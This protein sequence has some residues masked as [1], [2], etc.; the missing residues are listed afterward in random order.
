MPIVRQKTKRRRRRL[1]AVFAKLTPI[2]LMLVLVTLLAAA[3]GV[4]ALVLV[5]DRPPAASPLGDSPPLLTTPGAGIS[6]T[7]AAAPR[8]PET[9]RLVVPAGHIDLRV[10]PGDGFHVP[11]NLAVHY[12]GTS[13]PGGGGNSLFYAHAQ[14][15]MFAGLYDLH[16]G[17][18]IR[19]YRSDGSQVLYQVRTLHKVPATDLSV[20]KQTPFEEVTLLTC[21]SYNPYNPRYIVTATP[22]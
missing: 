14:P 22:V 19:A 16:L 8:T 13:E 3:G 1:T 12:P 6:S 21:T 11:L 20:V 15:G 4:A 10:V 7:P 17:D 9:V 2:Q 5:L 18:E